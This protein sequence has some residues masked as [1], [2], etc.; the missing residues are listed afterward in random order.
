[1]TLSI[2]LVGH[3]FKKRERTY[4]N[5]ISLTDRNRYVI[6]DYERGNFSVSQCNWEPNPQ[7]NI[8]AILK[9]VTKSSSSSSSGGQGDSS[10]GTDKSAAAKSVPTG[11]IA[12]G[13]VG[14]VALLALAA[15]L[16]YWFC[17]KPRRRRREAA[18]A[19]AAAATAAVDEPQQR[20]PSPPD[21]TLKPELD[22]EEIQKRHEMEAQKSRW[23]V[24][25]DGQQTFIYEMD[26]KKGVWAVE[27]DGTP[28]EV[29]EMPAMEEVAAELRGTRDSIEVAPR[30]PRWSWEMTDPMTS[31]PSLPSPE[32]ETIVEESPQVSETSP[33][34]DR[35]RL[36]RR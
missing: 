27:A 17:I 18:A 5:A 19:A 4:Q 2:P 30:P 34:S 24:E 9:P 22:S 35:T 15:F 25:A 28:V 14:G 31:P 8:V 32:N 33:Q 1:M 7:A 29:H 21:R 26:G 16:L 36:K 11:A 6:A 10:D 20:A 13:A 12:G 23:V 3:S